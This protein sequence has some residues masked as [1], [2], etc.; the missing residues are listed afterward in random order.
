MCDTFLMSLVTSTISLH[1]HAPAPTLAHML[2]ALTQISQP[3]YS[4]VSVSR[5]GCLVSSVRAS[6]P[7]SVD[8]AGQ[9]SPNMILVMM[10]LCSL[11][12]SQS[13]TSQGW[14]QSPVTDEDRRRL[15]GSFVKSEAEVS[16]VSVVRPLSISVID[17]DP[18]LGEVIL[19]NQ[20]GEPRPV[21][22]Q[23]E[24]SQSEEEE[25]RVLQGFFVD[26]QPLSEDNFSTNF[27]ADYE[28]EYEPSEDLEQLI[29]YQYDYPDDQETQEQQ[30]HHAAHHHQHHKHQ[31]Q[32]HPPQHIGIGRERTSKISI[33]P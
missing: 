6:L 23:P 2:R 1:F 14:S 11:A 4:P 21:R 33:V 5:V 16:E 18:V 31:P 29:E 12:S 22:Q 28:S 10:S 30:I 9:L 3:V 13:L 8:R 17:T 20:D 15:V 25:G 19:H 24:V 32:F 26:Q 7:H 27:E